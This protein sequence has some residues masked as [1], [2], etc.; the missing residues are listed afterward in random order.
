MDR[1][2]FP[3]Y[4]APNVLEKPIKG[5][6][7]SRFFYPD[8]LN[9]PQNVPMVDLYFSKA[10]LIFFTAPSLLQLVSSAYFD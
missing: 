9:N 6:V 8:G 1:L 10:I 2:Y 3:L 7:V 5:K 4:T